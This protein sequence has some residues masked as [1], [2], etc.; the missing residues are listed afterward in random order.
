[1]IITTKTILIIYCILAY[2]IAITERTHTFFR[3][4]KENNI[5]RAIEEVIVYT[6]WI[7]FILCPI[8]MPIWIFKRIKGE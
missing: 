3:A 1:M 2:L 8:L 7:G 4:I 6:D 5:K